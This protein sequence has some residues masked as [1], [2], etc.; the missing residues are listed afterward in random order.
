MLGLCFKKIFLFHHT[1]VG[2]GRDLSLHH[3]GNRDL[4]INKIYTM[5]KIL[6]ILFIICS[7]TNSYAI[8]AT[9]LV[10][11]CVEIALKSGEKFQ[12]EIVSNQKENFSYKKCNVV[13]AAEIM[14]SKKK[15]RV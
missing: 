2:T 6:F 4:Y 5:K 8:V 15:F 1:R 14:I 13:D 10:G 7:I 9:K 3:D 12:A 11:D